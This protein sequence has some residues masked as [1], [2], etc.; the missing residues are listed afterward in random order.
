MSLIYIEFNMLMFINIYE[1]VFGKWMK[2]IYSILMK[3]IV[4]LLGDLF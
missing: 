2:K 4:G 1:I 3:K